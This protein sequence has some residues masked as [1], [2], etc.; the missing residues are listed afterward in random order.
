MGDIKSISIDD[1]IERQQ[2]SQ[3]YQEAFRQLKTAYRERIA[4]TIDMLDGY[5]GQED[6]RYLYTE[7]LQCLLSLSHN[8]AGSGSTF[9]YPQITAK[10]R[11]VNVYLKSLL[12]P[13]PGLYDD[14]WQVARAKLLALRT[15]CVMALNEAG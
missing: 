7:G 2:S 3:R 4:E 1:F 8:M 11:E 6:P 5:L 9:G 12:S 14:A 13:E 10:G 15:A